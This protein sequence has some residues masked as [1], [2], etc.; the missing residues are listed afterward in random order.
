MKIKEGS[1]P[2]HQAS[3][4]ILQGDD[5]LSI[6]EEITALTQAVGQDVLSELNKIRLDGST[7][8]F[9]EI[10]MHL[11][12]LPLG[13]NKRIVIIDYVQ[14]VIGK[15][16]AQDWL[17][18]ELSNLTPTTILVLILEDEMKYRKGTMVWDVFDDDHWLQKIFSRFLKNACWIELSL[19]S[20]REMPDWIRKEAEKQGGSFHPRAAVELSRLIG[21]DLFQA[22]Q[23][24]GKAISYIGDDK[25]VS[26]D[27]VRLLCGSTKDENVFALVDAIG[28]RKGKLAFKLLH[29]IRT[30]MSIQYIFSMLVRQIR[31]LILAK[32]AVINNEGEKGVMASCK[33]R[34]T[35]I[36]KK[37]IDQSRHFD[38]ETLVNIYRKLDRIDEETKVGRVT[39]DVALER[40]IAGI[41]HK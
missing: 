18:D 9:K 33:L 11:K 16:G 6:E 41:A 26:A 28:Q 8:S 38:A 35:F 25:Q 27:V 37:L 13:G 34:H 21:N 5:R 19:P 7:L 1:L 22:R 32:E 2:T 12:V 17:N 20:D 10:S 4:I 24:I 39:L 30:E 36:A 31:L 40:L 14:E 29:R 3:I 23:E 15:K